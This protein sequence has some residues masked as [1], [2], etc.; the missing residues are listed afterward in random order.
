MQNR[1]R[2][3]KFA[4][5]G[6][7]FGALGSAVAWR[8]YAHGGYRGHGPI[9]PARL[10][11]HLER[12]L[13]HFYV[14]IDATEAQRARLEPIVK[15]AVKDLLPMR[16]RVHDARKQGLAVLTAQSVDRNALENLRAGQIQA[17]D[18]ASQRLVQALADVAD[19]L[20]AEQRKT[21]AERLQRR[22]GW[23]HG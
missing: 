17:A 23:R 7:L 13:K 9:D 4:G 19:V 16:E 5:L 21:L 18:A 20:T 12:M 10:E 3:F 8:A 22:R 11:E 14:E 6:A 2:F 15:Q 1:R